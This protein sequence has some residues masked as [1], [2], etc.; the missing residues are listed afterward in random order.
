MAKIVGLLVLAISLLS[1]GSVDLRAQ[2]PEVSN[3]RHFA[4]GASATGGGSAASALNLDIRI[5]AYTT[6]DQLG[7][8]GGILWDRGNDALRTKLAA[9]QVGSIGTTSASQAALAVARARTT[10][11]GVIIYLVAAQ[12]TPFLE[13]LWN[14][15]GSDPLTVFEL[16][17]TSQGSGEGIV[18]RI[19]QLEF[20]DDGSMALENPGGAELRLTQVRRID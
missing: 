4:A 10:P 17:L 14:A 1:V 13:P 11:D 9:E 16:R 12:P 2:P 5:T 20:N 8:Y 3:W 19:G 15:S 7:A 18:Y 6:D